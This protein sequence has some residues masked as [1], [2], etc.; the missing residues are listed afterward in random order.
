MPPGER[1]SGL[2]WI[3][4]RRKDQRAGLLKRLGQTG[5][6]DGVDAALSNG[7]ISGRLHEGSKLRIGDL[8]AVH[9]ESGGLYCTQLFLRINRITHAIE[10]G[11][12]PHHARR[13]LSLRH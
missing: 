1:V 12:N 6:P 9:P 2:T 5:V 11:R 3:G 13:R 4:R 10:T 7:A 8:G